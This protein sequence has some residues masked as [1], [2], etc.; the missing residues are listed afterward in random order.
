MIDV[1]WNKLRINFS[2]L[3]S[4]FMMLGIANKIENKTFFIYCL[5]HSQKGKSRQGI[6]SKG[7]EIALRLE[8][9]SRAVFIF[10]CFDFVNPSLRLAGERGCQQEL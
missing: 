2:I 8:V 10:A 5:L 7:K 9:I 1:F 4:Y 3:N 6:G